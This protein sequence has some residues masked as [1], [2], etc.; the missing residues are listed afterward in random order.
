MMDCEAVKEK[1]IAYIFGELPD[2]A[3]REVSEHLKA[4]KSC[5]EECKS[6]ISIVN[7]LRDNWISAPIKRA[8]YRT[9]ISVRRF[10]GYAIA[11]VLLMLAIFNSRFYYDGVTRS[12]EVSFSML[13]RTADEQYIQEVLNA[14]D[15]RLLAVFAEIIGQLEAR[16]ADN[17]YTMGLYLEKGGER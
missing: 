6:L 8:R 17:F 14:R 4:C 7:T 12:W 3:Q 5:S 10:I 16:W 2:P 1:L 13:P 9:R 11:G 15:E